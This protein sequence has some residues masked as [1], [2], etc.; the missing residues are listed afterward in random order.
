[1]I[2]LEQA[3]V[4][5]MESY[6]D[7]HFSEIRPSILKKLV[8]ADIFFVSKQEYERAILSKIERINADLLV[9]DRN[10]DL[11]YEKDIHTFFSPV[12]LKKHAKYIFDALLL[13]LP[14]HKEYLT[15]NLSKVN[16]QID[17]IFA[18]AAKDFASHKGEYIFSYHSI[19]HYFADY[20]GFKDYS[21]SRH[22]S[23]PS[24]LDLQKMLN[25]MTKN[26]AKFILITEPDQAVKVQPIL[27]N[28]GAVLIEVREAESNWQD[29]LNS[30]INKIQS[31]FNIK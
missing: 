28:T 10:Q 8:K 23:E 14:D 18:K 1:M 6:H 31:G 4:A 22:H 11:S 20:F 27:D 3:R 26:S 9:V 21:L 12:W 29:T 30:L 2:T 13:K 17:Q 16:E 19:I 7:P 24:A 5:L 25:S 15:T